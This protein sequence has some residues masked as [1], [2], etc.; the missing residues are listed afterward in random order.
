MDKVI[1]KKDGFW[2][3]EWDGKKKK[4]KTWK[5]N[6]TTHLFLEAWHHGLEI[7]GKVRLKDLVA[8]LKKFDPLVLDLVAKL[9]HANLDE[10]LKDENVVAKRDPD[11]KSKLTA[12]E[13]YKYYE[14]SNYNDIE[15]WD[16]QDHTVS[17]HGIGAYWEEGC[18]DV[19]LEKRGNSY[20]IEFT[21]WAY[22]LNL[23]L[24]MKQTVVLCKHKWKKQKPKK[25]GFKRKGSKKFE[26]GLSWVSDRTTD[27]YENT[28]VRVT[29]ELGEFLYGLF[30]ELCFFWSPN[31]RD[32]KEKELMKS[33]EDAK[34]AKPEDFSE[35]VEE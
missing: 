9:C 11:R 35:L 16:M 23:P 31:R 25:M 33:C 28:D 21:P 29:Y 6:T 8:V 5:I 3:S 4:Y 13:V 14:M 10:Y 20:A 30:N 26:R 22:L 17:A 2:A 15:K 27:G 12:I 7:K 32:E 24:T 1:L 34:N 18:E 19:P